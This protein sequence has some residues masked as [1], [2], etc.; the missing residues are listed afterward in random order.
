KMTTEAQIAANRRNA[1]RSTGPKSA[2]G[3]QRSRTNAW[4]HGLSA[5]LICMDHEDREEFEEYRYHMRVSMQLATD[6]EEEIAERIIVASW[7]RRR[8][9]AMEKHVMHFFTTDDFRLEEFNV[10]LRYRGSIEREYHKC[11]ADLDRLQ[12]NR[13]RRLHLQAEGH[14]ADVMTTNY[15]LNKPMDLKRIAAMTMAEYI[16]AN[17]ERMTRQHTPPTAVP[18]IEDDETKP[19]GPE[20][21]VGTDVAD[22]ETEATGT[23]RKPKSVVA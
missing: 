7:K 16:R 19:I 18:E 5:N 3:K 17:H 14:A 8:L 2:R 15:L 12:K 1:Q 9:E 4:K 21:P 23:A 10:L 13:D 22:D 6:I 20:K 11:V